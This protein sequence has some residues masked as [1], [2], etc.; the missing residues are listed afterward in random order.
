[1]YYVFN[2]AIHDNCYYVAVA[3]V[4]VLFLFSVILTNTGVRFINALEPR[5]RTSLL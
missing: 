4:T 3:C 1:M 2:Q 5:L